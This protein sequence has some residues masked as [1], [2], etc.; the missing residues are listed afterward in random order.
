[1][2][3]IQVT[4]RL[5]IHDGKLEEFEDAAVKCMESVRAKDTG[6][7]QYDWFFNADGS[8]CVVRET[9]RD[10]EAVL[11]HMTNLGGELLGALLAACD[12]EAEFFGDP[13]EEL[14]EALSSFGPRVYSPYQSI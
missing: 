12:L 14:L 3:K 8:E 11:E 5:R 9:Y 4:A 6:T 7:L 2:S 13:S 1:M 10:S